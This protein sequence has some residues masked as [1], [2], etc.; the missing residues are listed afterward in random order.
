ME[1]VQACYTRR[2][3]LPVR[4]R[5]IRALGEEWLGEL[6]KRYSLAGERYLRERLA[7]GE[8]FGAFLEGR[9]AGFIGL[10][11]EGS[12]GMLWVDEDCRRQGIG[13]SLEAWLINRLLERGETPYGQ[14]EAGNLG[15]IRLQERLGLYLAEGYVWW[16]EDVQP[17]PCQTSLAAKSR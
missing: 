9:L 17:R 13:A 3:P 11:E 15:S 12:M 1:C 7:K 2:E 6:Q 16:V 5:D 8:I 4:H 10:H 14:I